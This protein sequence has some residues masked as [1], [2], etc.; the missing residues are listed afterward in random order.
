M[1]ELV[2]VSG[3]GGTGKTTITASLSAIAPNHVV[4]DCDVDAPNLHLLLSPHVEHTKEFV[5]SKL[6]VI[7]P[8][9]CKE[10]GACE[11]ACRFGA[12][13]VDCKVDPIL[14]E[15]CG[16]CSA[17]C[18]YNAIQMKDRLS[19]YIYT[20][21]TEYGSMAHAQL[22]AGESNSGKLVTTV[23]KLAQELA[24]REEA[25]FVLID[26][27]PGIAC[28]TIAAITGV[29]AGLVVAEPTVP[30]IHDLERVLQ[31][32]THFQIPTMVVI[33]KYDLNLQKTKIIETYCEDQGIP[34][35]GQIPYDIIATKAIV[36]GRPIVEYAPKH[37]VSRMLG[38][39]WQAVETQLSFE[40]SGGG[41]S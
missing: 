2:V 35:V 36:A 37:K 34:V 7:I 22:F 1:K 19:G 28:P 17:I 27:P 25:P 5:A 4:A 21:E 39:L 23:R 20:S 6:A 26:G 24:K 11:L 8:E 15:G 30:A 29:S 12:I 32:F 18:P 14:C 10:C 33:N 16:V 38:Q 41:R 9:L 31:L 13:S 40:K 3:K